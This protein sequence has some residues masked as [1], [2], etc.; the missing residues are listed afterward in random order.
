MRLLSPVIRWVDGC[1]RGE[2]E[3]RAAA[4]ISDGGKKEVGTVVEELMPFSQSSY[5][6]GLARGVASN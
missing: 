3:E 5:G 4:R 6:S 2:K 1:S